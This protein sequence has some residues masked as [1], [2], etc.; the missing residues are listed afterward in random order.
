MTHAGSNAHDCQPSHLGELQRI[1]SREEIAQLEAQNLRQTQDHDR[2]AQEMQRTFEVRM[3]EAS[4]SNLSDVSAAA[5]AQNIL[6]QE[7][8]VASSAHSTLREEI[9]YER[10]AIHQARIGEISRTESFEQRLRQKD[11][12][13]E[14]ARK[15]VRRLER[16]AREARE[17]DRGR[18][19]AKVWARRW[20]PR[21][22]RSC[23]RATKKAGARRRSEQTRK[24]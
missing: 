24:G 4:H 22:E 19:D 18:G 2:Y 17:Q 21:W 3:A 15:N 7:V 6:R 10:N 5:A 1:R 11:D 9:Q 14:D 13:E 20:T 12:E 8:Q 23:V 16:A